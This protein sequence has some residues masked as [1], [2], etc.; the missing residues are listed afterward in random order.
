M[1]GLFNLA[2]NEELPLSRIEVIRSHGTGDSTY[3]IK[4]TEEDHWRDL[5]PHAYRQLASRPVQ[6]LPANPPVEL[7][8]WNDDDELEIW[9]EPVIAWALCFDGQVRP[10]TA[11]GVCNG[12]DYQDDYVRYPDGRISA[13]GSTAYIVGFDDTDALRT[14]LLDVRRIA[15]EHRASTAAAKLAEGDQA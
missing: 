15:E 8:C 12:S 5:R 9:F 14:H 2:W 3:R 7:V 1:I 6:L 10:V 4:L 11:S 13:I